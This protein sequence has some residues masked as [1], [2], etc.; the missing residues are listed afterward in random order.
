[1]RN[2]DCKKKH[3]LRTSKPERHRLEDF[4]PTVNVHLGINVKIIPKCY[5]LRFLF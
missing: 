5:K 2:V 3:V 1:M 4:D